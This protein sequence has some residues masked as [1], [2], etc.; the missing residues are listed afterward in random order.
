MKKIITLIIIL[1]FPINMLAY[2]YYIIPGGDTIG[3][4]IKSDGVY[5]VGFY[6]IDGKNINQFLNIGDKIIKIG[7]ENINSTESLIEGIKKYEKDE[8][9]SIMYVRDGILKDGL[10]ELKKDSNGYKTGIY[11]K[12]DTLGIGTLTYIDPNSKVYGMLGHSLNFSFNNERIKIDSGTSYE[13]DVKSFT[14]S[15]NGNPGSKNALI[16][17]EKQFGN[18]SKNSNYGIFGNTN[19]TIERETIPIGTM[20][21]IKLGKAYIYTSNIEDEIK[22]YEIKII[23]INKKHND[24]NI[25]FE[26]TDENLINLSGGIVQGMSGSPIIQDGKIIGAVT[27]VLIDDVKKGYGISIIT[28]LE[29]GD[30]INKN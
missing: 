8:K 9:V 23:D 15:Q 10:L 11:V 14:K 5:V 30:K 7:E 22:A 12:G 26:I 13:T 18:I 1:L 19:K 17:K 3:I 25:Y 6:K 16:I 21:E 24:K 20:D 4:E 2:S 28:M 27:R 29:E